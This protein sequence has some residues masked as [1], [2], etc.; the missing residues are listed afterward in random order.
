MSAPVAY[1]ATIARLSSAQPAPPPQRSP[2]DHRPF[3]T[4]AARAH[5]RQRGMSL[6]QV[7]TGLRRDHLRLADVIAAAPAPTAPASAGAA[8]TGSAPSADG[9]VLRAALQAP[10][11]QLSAL[12]AAAT[13]AFVVAWRAHGSGAALRYVRH[14]AAGP[15]RTVLVDP[16]SYSSDGLVRRLADPPGAEDQDCALVIHDLTAIPGVD[17]ALGLDGGLVAVTL[18]APRAVAVVRSGGSGLHAI[19]AAAELAASV[20]FADS[21]PDEMRL[22]VLAAVTSAFPPVA[23]GAT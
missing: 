6:E 5:A 19:G 1:G 22:A 23:G 15:V 7:A 21:V 13:H 17:G 10:I 14:G 3:A 4:P 16:A 12:G 20:R 11:G 8:P 18:G 2:D 9:G